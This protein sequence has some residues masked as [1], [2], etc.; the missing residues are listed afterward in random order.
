MV[1]A[2]TD[3]A[4]AGRVVQ[5]S[6]NREPSAGVW[7]ESRVRSQHADSVDLERALQNVRRGGAIH[8]SCSGRVDWGNGMRATKVPGWSAA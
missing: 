3:I 5:S 6:L 8:L 1:R 7:P 2:G 4:C